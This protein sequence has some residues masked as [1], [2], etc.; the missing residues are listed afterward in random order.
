MK[1]IISKHKIH[2]SS[3]A[4][5]MSVIIGALLLISGLFFNTLASN[6]AGETQSNYVSDFFLDRVP[7]Q[8]V[9]GLIIGGT[10][11][12]IFFSVALLVV[13]PRRIP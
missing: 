6:Y 8:D 5:I 2:W 13:E 12:L 11:I 10:V 7:T 9:D 1:E 4:F 3:R